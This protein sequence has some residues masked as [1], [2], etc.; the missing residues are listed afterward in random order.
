[1]LCQTVDPRFFRGGEAT[2]QEKQASFSEFKGEKRAEPA[3]PSDASCSLCVAVC[4]VLIHLS[5]PVV[6]ASFFVC[7]V[8]FFRAPLAA[9]GGSQAGGRIGARSKLRLRPTPQLTAMMDP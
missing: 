6:V 9:Y 1:M 2:W 7:F 8:L 5:V 4:T 3:L